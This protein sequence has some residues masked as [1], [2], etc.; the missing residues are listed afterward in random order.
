MTTNPSINNMNSEN[1]QVVVGDVPVIDGRVVIYIIKADETSYINYI[2]P[3]ILARE[4]KVP[5]VLSLIDTTSQWAY[6]IHPERMVPALKDADPE[7]DERINVFEGTACLQYLADRF[8]VHGEWSGRTA[9]ERG[10]VFT[11]VAYQTAGIGATAKYWLYFLRGYPTRKNSV[12]LP[13][14]IAKLHENTIKQ[15]DI[16]NQQLGKDGQH[17]VALADRPTIADLSYFPFAMPWMFNFLGVNIKDW[18]HIE[19]WAERLLARP[20][21]Q[22]IMAQAKTFGHN[23]TPEELSTLKQAA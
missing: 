8:D 23:M 14:T 2:K 13:R 5:H 7:T 20:A 10:A 17:Y 18:P 9:A 19:A 1:G 21:I 4:L 12:Q 16:L 6:Q 15:W 22:E 11:W 3:L